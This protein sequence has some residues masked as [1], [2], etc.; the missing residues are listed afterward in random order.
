MSGFS[1][2]EEH[3]ALPTGAVART[4][5]HMLRLDGR[6]V[7]GITR[8]EYR[9]YLYPLYTPAGFAVTAES[10]ADHPHHHSLWVGADHVGVSLPAPDG[11]REFYDYNCYVN[12]NFQGRAP[13]RI[14]ETALEGESVG[15]AFRLE[16]SLEWRGPGEWGADAGRLLMREAR[17][18]RVAIAGDAYVIDLRCH[19]AAIDHPVRI[20]PTRHA[21]FN[22]RVTPSMSVDSGGLLLDDR[23]A[24]GAA[25]G[26]GTHARW[27]DASGPV[28]GGHT[29]GVAL[30][31]RA[32]GRHWWWFV[33][34]WGVATASPCRDEAIDLERGG[35]VTLA[36]RYVVHDGTGDSR[37][38][39][40]IFGSA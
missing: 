19:L 28:G 13:G 37:R 40:E 8:G 23:G 6:P 15:A 26:I 17:T 27:V 29:A 2:D 7:L 11:R 18:T 20:G 12:G 9:P 31:P 1:L 24:H 35:T 16:Q 32:D 4:R 25:A 10:P 14:L 3:I 33:S 34:D 39:A 36:A 38:L 21:W 22:L 30:A 5:R